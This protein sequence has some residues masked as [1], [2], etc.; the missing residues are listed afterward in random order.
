MLRNNQILIIKGAPEIIVPRCTT[1]YNDHLDEIEI[2][3]ALTQKI[4][5]TVDGI[6]DTGI[7]VIAIATS[8]EP[9]LDSE[10][11]VLPKTLNL[12]VLLD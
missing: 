9:K 2:S 3:D 6:S 8:H 10:G 5:D 7:R 4:T 1:Y 12:V 11:S